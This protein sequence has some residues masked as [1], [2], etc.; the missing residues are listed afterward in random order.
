MIHLDEIIQV[1]NNRSPDR[2][3]M[4]Y[5]LVQFFNPVSIIDDQIQYTQNINGV[6]REEHW[7]KHW[8]AFATDEFGSPIF[9]DMT[10]GKIYTANN[11]NSE[12]Q[13]YY[14]ATSLDNYINALVE[15]NNIAENRETP[16]QLKENPVPEAISDSIIAMIDHANPGIDLWYW[17]LFMENYDDGNDLEEP[18]L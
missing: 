13:A 11:D 15:I 10:S 6:S 18:D 14:V 3:G 2:V 12:W 16:D 8:F 9:L 4:G 5:R 1:L 17:E 7:Q